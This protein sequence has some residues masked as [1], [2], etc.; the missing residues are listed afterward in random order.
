MKNYKEKTLHHIKRKMV[1]K[2]VAR[3]S[4]NFIELIYFEQP[5]TILTDWKECYNYI[6]SMSKSTKRSWIEK[7]VN[8]DNTIWDTDLEPEEQD[9]VDYLLE[10]FD[11]QQGSFEIEELRDLLD[12]NTD[13]ENMVN[14]CSI[15][16]DA[17]ISNKKTLLEVE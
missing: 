6:K 5:L 3:E 16:I 9:C 4:D 17:L 1:S 15:L 12:E 13:N 2:Y 11:Y 10:Y 8:Q 7:L 14:T